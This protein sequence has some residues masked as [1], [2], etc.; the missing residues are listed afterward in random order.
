MNSTL[1]TPGPGLGRR[2]G[3]A[4]PARPRHPG[5]RARR[6]P[7]PCPPGVVGEL[8]VGGDGLARGYLG[9]PD[10]TA[11]RFVADPFTPEPGARMYRTGDLV[12]LAARRRPRLP[13]P[14]RRAGQGA[15]LPDRARPRSRRCSASHP[16][17][18]RAAVVLREDR[19]GV[20][21]LVGYVVPRSGGRGGRR[22]LDPTDVRAHAE[23]RAARPHG[24]GRRGRRR[25]PAPQPRGKLDRAALPAPDLT[26]LSTGVAPRTGREAPLAAPDGRRA[27]ACPRWV[28]RTTSSSSAATASRPSS[29]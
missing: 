14:R 23:L 13:R 3:A 2:R 9:R 28:S 17:V 29:S 24:P 20:K 4:R 25:R 27:R 12:G 10:L 6:R 16:G 18:A 11:E 19:P 15:G 5:L 22:P 21:Q 7:A 1:W 8:Y 26:A